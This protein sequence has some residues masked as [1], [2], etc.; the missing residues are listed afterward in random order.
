M[1]CTFKHKKISPMDN[2]EDLEN[3]K[4]R[5]LL[6][7]NFLKTMLAVSDCQ[8]KINLINKRNVNGEFIASDLN[9][10]HFQIK[11]LETPLGI[12]KDALMRRQD[13]ESITFEK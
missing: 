8:V 1:K 6:R 2:H 4:V 10:G 7:E 9:V 3:Q 5:T 11:N 13:I 12:Q